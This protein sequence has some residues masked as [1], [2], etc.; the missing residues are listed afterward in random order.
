MIG[1]IRALVDRLKARLATDAALDLEAQLLAGSAARKAALLRLAEQ[2]ASEGLDGVAIQ[3]RRQAQ[4]L[5]Q[6][7][8][9]DSALRAIERLQLDASRPRLR[10]ADGTGAAPSEPEDGPV[11]LP[12]PHKTPKKRGTKR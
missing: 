11:L 12:H 1:Y 2:Y 10:I 8:P 7:R 9:L 3:L 6:H 4:E 5:D